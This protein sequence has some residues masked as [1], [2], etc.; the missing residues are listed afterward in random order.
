MHIYFDERQ[1]VKT[2]TL[3]INDKNSF[4]K[5][6]IVKGNWQ[7]HVIFGDWT[8]D[9]DC[10]Y[11]FSF[12]HN[13]TVEI[14]IKNKTKQ[15][16]KEKKNPKK[17]KWTVLLIPKATTFKLY[18]GKNELIAAEKHKDERCYLKTKLIK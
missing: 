4:T 11:I 16:P 18:S 7:K 2:T 10:S 12:I 1:G 8:V 17:T 9:P 3:A 6:N 14:I 13:M 15:T 5:Q